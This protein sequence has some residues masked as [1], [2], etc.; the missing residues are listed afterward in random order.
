M[1]IHVRYVSIDIDP[2]LRFNGRT[3]TAIPN[4]EW[5]APQPSKTKSFEAGQQEFTGSK[6]KE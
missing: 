6:C 3:G 4:P 1:R 2:L 5:P